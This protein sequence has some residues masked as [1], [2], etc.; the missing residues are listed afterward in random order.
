MYFIG[1]DVHQRMTVVC[2]LNT[3]GHIVQRQK[4]KGGWDRV[5]DWLAQVNQPF[6][7]AYETSSGYGWLYDQLSQLPLAQKVTSAHPG[8]LR[9]IFESKQKHDAGD[10][11][12]IA[13]MLRAGL[14]KASYV[15][16]LQVREWRSMI[17]TRRQQ[18]AK[19]TRAKNQIRAILRSHAI[20]GLSCDRQWTKAGIAWLNQLELPLASRI[21]LEML[22]EQIDQLNQQIKRLEKHLNTQ[23]RNHPG[24]ALLCTIPGVGIRTAEA[25]MATIDDPWRFKKA[26]QIGPYLGL[27]PSEYSTG[28]RQRLGH[29][30]KQGSPLCRQLLC[31]A[32]WQ[33]IRLS[34]TLK[35]HFER[36]CQGDPQRKKKALVGTARHIAVCM[37]AMLRSGETWQESVQ[38]DPPPAQAA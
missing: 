20:P 35:A 15:P 38:S 6:E 17:E 18:V 4:I 21:N 33:A 22:L 19:R 9:V 14:L 28:G 8:A 25:M 29:I 11:E 31:E 34:P 23:A 24:V 13:Q 37:L 7:I 5:M 12:K 16:K 10:A 26:K 27:T 3:Q 32:T 2:I 1:M 30:T 36:L